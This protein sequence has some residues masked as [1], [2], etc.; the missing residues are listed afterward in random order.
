MQIVGSDRQEQENVK[1]SYLA[2]PNSGGT[3]EKN[4]KNKNQEGKTQKKKNSGMEIRGR[5]KKGKEKECTSW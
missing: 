2:R 1:V 5:R 3:N 4:I